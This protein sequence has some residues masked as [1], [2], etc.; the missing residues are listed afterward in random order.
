MIW[1][2]PKNVQMF[3]KVLVGQWRERTRETRLTQMDM[4]NNRLHEHWSGHS[5]FIQHAFVFHLEAINIIFESCGKVESAPA[6]TRLATHTHSNARWQS[7]YFDVDSGESTRL[8]TIKKN[9]FPF[10][11]IVCSVGRV[12]RSKSN[13]VRKMSGDRIPLAKRWKSTCLMHICN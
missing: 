13:T 9:R 3:P 10:K 1:A 12:A 5:F 11:Q 6:D 8:C 2:E 4:I 7:G